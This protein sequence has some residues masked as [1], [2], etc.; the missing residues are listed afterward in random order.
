M[1]LGCTHYP[2][3][4]EKISAYLGPEVELISSA[5]ETA[6]EISTL[7]YHKGQLAAGRGMPV[8]QFF[9]SG[10]AGLFRKIAREWLDAEIEVSTVVWQNPRLA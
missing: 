7:L 2:F 6:R 3:I 10:D 8:H 5:E 9:C 1:I 4:A